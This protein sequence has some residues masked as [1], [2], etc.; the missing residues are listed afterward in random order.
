[1]GVLFPIQ[2]VLY[3]VGVVLSVRGYWAPLLSVYASKTDNLVYFRGPS[4]DFDRFAA[5]SGDPGWSWSSMQQF[6]TEV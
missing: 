2:E 5:V 6:I 3:W 1:M 4:E